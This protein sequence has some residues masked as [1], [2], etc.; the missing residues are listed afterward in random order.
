M[1]LLTVAVVVLWVLMLLLSVLVVLL[2]RQFGLI[3]IGSRARLGLTGLA[4]GSRVPEVALLRMAGRDFAWDWTAGG[5]GRGTL[6]VFGAPGCTLCKKLTPQLNLFADKWAHLVDLIFVEKGPL[7]AGPTHDPPN[8]TQWMY[9]ED[10]EGELHR[11]FDIEA[12]PYAF[13][14]DS[15]RRVLAKGIVNDKSDIEAVLS[16][17]VTEEGVLNPEPPVG[18]GRL[19]QTMDGRGSSDGSVLVEPT[20]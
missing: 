14:V 4:V 10:P 7:P 5:G 15:S 6:V 2:Y 3:Y 16:M 1:S 11:A 12:T 19:I 20:A 13:V 8:R 18:P 17:A 9:T